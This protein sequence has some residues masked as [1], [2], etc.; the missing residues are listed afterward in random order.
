MKR[1][2]SVSC[3]LFLVMCF[4]IPEIAFAQGTFE[5]NNTLFGRGSGV[6]ATEYVTRFYRWAVGIAIFASSV[7]IIWAGYKYALSKGNPTEVGSAKEMI[8]SILVG[9]GLLILAYTILRFIGVGV[10]PAAGA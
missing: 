6:T 8:I 4:V 9:L 3:F 10:T 5:F 2:V 7:G 1:I